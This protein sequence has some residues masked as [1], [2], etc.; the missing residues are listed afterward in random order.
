MSERISINIESLGINATH[1]YLVPDDMNVGKLTELIIKTMQDEY[2]GVQN[3]KGNMHMLMQA[4]TGKVL[5]NGCSLR[6]MGT[7]TGETFILI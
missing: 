4:S 7:V 3:K 6:Q 1:N 5:N 2:S